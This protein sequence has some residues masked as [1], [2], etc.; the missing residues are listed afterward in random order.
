[1]KL[2]AAFQ[3]SNSTVKDV[4]VLSEATLKQISDGLDHLESEIEDCRRIL[5]GEKPKEAGKNADA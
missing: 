3:T 2:S 1:M 4:L 5:R